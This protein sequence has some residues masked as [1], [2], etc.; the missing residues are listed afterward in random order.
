MH[1][2][3]WRQKAYTS[4]P[5]D[6]SAARTLGEFLAMFRL[7]TDN[8][9]RVLAPG[10]RIAILMGDYSDR[11]I[12]FVPLVYYVK[13]VCFQAGLRQPCT[14]IIRFSYG[15]SSSRREYQSSFIPGLHDVVTVFER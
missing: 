4:D 8:C 2:P 10:G 5:R 14:E 13:G 9:T 15:A 7:V 6:L 12:G 11:E 1:P 3:Y